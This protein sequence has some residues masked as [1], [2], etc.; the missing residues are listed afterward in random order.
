MPNDKNKKIN[1]VFNKYK[2]EFLSNINGKLLILIIL[3]QFIVKKE[4]KYLM[5][6]L[7]SIFIILFSNNLLTTINAKPFLI[8]KTTCLL[9]INVWSI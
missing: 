7:N 8:F 5:N 9:L 2:R 4:V 1:I 6:L 3:I